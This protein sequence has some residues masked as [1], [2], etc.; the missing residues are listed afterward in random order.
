[1]VRAMEIGVTVAAFAFLAVVTVL[2]A[3]RLHP[4]AGAVGAQSMQEDQDMMHNFIGHWVTGDGH[5]R[6]ELRADGRF[7]EARGN[8]ERAYSGRYRL[9]GNRIEYIDDS[10]FTAEGQFRDGILYQSGIVLYPD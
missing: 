4:E 2:P 5:V 1:M 3:P 7:V 6:Q 9:E 10:G 8:Q